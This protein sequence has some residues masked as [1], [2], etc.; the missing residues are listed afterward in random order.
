MYDERTRVAIAEHAHISRCAWQHVRGVFRG[1]YVMLKWEIDT[2]S[3]L[4]NVLLQ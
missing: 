2:K 3:E 1:V 4:H